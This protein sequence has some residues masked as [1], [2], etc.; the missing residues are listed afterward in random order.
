MPLVATSEI[1]AP[2]A[3]RRIGAG[4]CHVIG[5]EHADAIAA[6][7]DAVA[8]EVPRRLAVLDAAGTPA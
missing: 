5:L 4:S 3:E 8:G 1:I 2:S 6:G 7:R